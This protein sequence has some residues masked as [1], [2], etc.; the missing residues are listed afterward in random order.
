MFK[1]L[2]VLLVLTSLWVAL[3]WPVGAA[4]PL[5]GPS[6][7]PLI[8]RLKQNTQNNVRISYHAGTGMVS[9]IGADPAHSI[10][11]PARLPANTGPEAAAR[12][13]LAHYGSLFGLKEP[14]AEL[15]L[16]KQKALPDGRAFVRF[17]QRYQG[18]PVVGGELIVQ[19]DGAQNIISA[20]GEILPELKL[21]PIPTVSAQTAR[22]SALVKVAKDYQ[23]SPEL[24]TAPAIMVRTGATAPSR[25]PVCPRGS[26]PP[27]CVTWIS[28]DHN[29][30]HSCS[31]TRTRTASPVTATT[32]RR[33]SRGRCGRAA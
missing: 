26:F 28:R 29:R 2:K 22:Q 14:A 31:R 11:Q 5:Q 16:M 15:G 8:D 9:F 23:L 32:T 18:I 19:T 21:D 17:Q 7:Q 10:V 33:W 20:N 3:T 13:F 30:S 25:S 12:G 1:P 6:N 24:A 4:P 27:R